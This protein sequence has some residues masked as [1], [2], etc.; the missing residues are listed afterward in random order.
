MM[1]STDADPRC[2]PGV[3]MVRIKM[4]GALVAMHTIHFVGIVGP[5]N[6]SYVHQDITYQITGLSL[7][8]SIAA[9]GASTKL[10]W[11]QRTINYELE[12]TPVLD[13]QIWSPVTTLVQT[14]NDSLPT[15][16]TK[17][18]EPIFPAAQSV[19]MARARAPCI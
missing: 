1:N 18:W 3:P 14:N 2:S 16:I 6:A 15:I 19:I 8:L 7:S 4:R 9:Q 5:T 10:S 12:N 11:P 17:P 13:S